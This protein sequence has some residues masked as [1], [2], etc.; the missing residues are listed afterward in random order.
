MYG[1]REK[2][3]TIVADLVAG[4]VIHGAEEVGLGFCTVVFVGW[5]IK[6]V[7]KLAVVGS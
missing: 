5:C 6:Q 2:I 7:R 1:E 4:F 3:N